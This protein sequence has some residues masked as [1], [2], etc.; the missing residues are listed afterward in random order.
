[1][2][3]ARLLAIVLLGLAL[4]GCGSDSGNDEAASTNPSSPPEMQTIQT[5]PECMALP[6][7]GLDGVASPAIENRETMY[8]TGVSEDTD[9]NECS[10]V[11]AFTFEKQPPG[12]GFDVSY[13]PASTA[14]IQDGSGDTIEIEGN[15]FLVV[16]LMPAMTAKIEGEQVTKTYTGPNRVKPDVPSFVKEVVKTGDFE[17]QVTWVIGLDQKRA[18]KVSASAAGL[19]IDIDGS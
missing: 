18:F 13:Q 9:E 15:A 1:V 19:E 4:A 2:T 5:I 14:K 12:P 6:G 11:V 10:A 8:L 3:V 7:A 17:A 16:R